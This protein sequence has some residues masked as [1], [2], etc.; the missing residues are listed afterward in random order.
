M[1][2]S[3]ISEN[4]ENLIVRELTLYLLNWNYDTFVHNR[5]QSLKTLYEACENYEKTGQQRFKES[6]DSYFS[7]DATTLDLQDLVDA[8]FYSEDVI[9]IIL[10]LIT[11]DGQKGSKKLKSLRKIEKIQFSLARY[12]ES[13]NNN[14]ALDLMSGLCRLITNTFDDADGRS[15]LISY[16]NEFQNFDGEADSIV[17]L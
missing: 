13:Y 7:M 11:V 1:G 2:F 16:F 12:L 5:R 14:P 15:R 3:E 17:I 6:L 10:N 8:D 9:D 4:P